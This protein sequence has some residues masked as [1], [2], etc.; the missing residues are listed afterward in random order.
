MR[1]L[2]YAA[3]IAERFGVFI[4]PSSRTGLDPWADLSRIKPT[5]SFEI[6]FDV[7]AHH[8]ETVLELRRRAPNAQIHAFE[9]FPG[10]FARLRDVVGVLPNVRCWE[11]AVADRRGD[12]LLHL[13][14]T[15]YEFSLIPS[16]VAADAQVVTVPVTTL[17]QFA[18]QQGIKHV[19]LLKTDTEGADLDVLRG[20][21]DLLARGAVD[22]IY[23]EFGLDDA[24][25]QHTPLSRVSEFLSRFHFR[26]LGL[27]EIHHFPDPW[28]LGFGNALFTRLGATK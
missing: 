3:R 21:S 8:G 15:D 16:K 1:G 17:D 13:Q 18:E 27:Y 22:S 14:G 2:G 25:K 9:P 23:A 6:I 5:A 4:A 26:L 24:D 10:S 19:D 28:R 11:T 7:G 12:A 20:A